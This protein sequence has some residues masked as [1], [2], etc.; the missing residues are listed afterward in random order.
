MNDI[1]DVT[2]IGGGPSGLYS[3]FYA[4]LRDLK[5]KIIEFQPTLG[6]KLHVYPEKIIWDIGGMPPTPAQQVIENLI[7]QGLTFKPTVCLNTKVDFITKKDDLFVIETS[8][9][10]KHYSKKVIV[11]VGGGIISPIKLHIEGAEKYEVSNLHYTIRGIQSFKDKSLLISGGG[12]SAIDWAKDLIGIAKQI[13]VIYRGEKLSA[14]EAQIRH[15]QDN[16]VPII[17][18]TQIKTLVANETKTKIEEVILENVVTMETSKIVVDDVLVNHGYDRDSSFS[19]DAALS[20]EKDKDYDYYYL[21]DGKGLTSV[22]GIYAVGD[23]SKYDNKVYLITGT[24]QDAVNAINAIKISLEP[25]ADQYAKVSSH[26]EVFEKRN[27][28]LMKDI[29]VNG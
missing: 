7:K 27:R 24:F 4:G 14:H 16:G 18:N 28:E 23:I 25:T 12:N 9:G 2:I 20:P 26:N 21:T 1:Y 22:D 13:T 19:F 17:T 5:T 29:L 15:L 6:G 3:A 10:E 8:S 11:A